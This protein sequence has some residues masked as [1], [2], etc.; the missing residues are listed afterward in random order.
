MLH[1]VKSLVCVTKTLK[2]TA[3]IAAMPQTTCSDLEGGSGVSSHCSSGLSM[4][5]ATS[6]H[7]NVCFISLEGMR[8]KGQTRVPQ[9]HNQVPMNRSGSA[10]SCFPQPVCE[11]LYGVS[12]PQNAMLCKHSCSVSPR[13][14]VGLPRS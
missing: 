7:L 4:C 2:R 1:P 8:W 6:R 14:L 5:C 11:E 12:S 9:L 3:W 13:A 10:S